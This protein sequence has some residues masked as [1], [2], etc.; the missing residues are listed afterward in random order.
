M[1][2]LMARW[3][4]ALGGMTLACAEGTAPNDGSFTVVTTTSGAG[5]DADGYMLRIDSDRR[6]RL[7]TSDTV[8]L[9]GLAAGGHELDLEGIAPNCTV[10]GANIRTVTVSPGD[11][12]FVRFDVACAGTAGTLQLTVM[13][14]GMDID[15]SGY[16]ALLDGL[17]KLAVGANA[18]ASTNVPSGT[19]QVTLAGVAA[20]CTL[21]DTGAR[22]AEIL[23][24]GITRVAFTLHCSASAPAGRG[25]E[26]AFVRDG[27]EG[28]DALQLNRMYLMNED[29]TSL[30]PL[31][32]VS[33][34]EHEAPDWLPDGVHL[35]F[36]GVS[37]D[38]GPSFGT[39]YILDLNNGTIQPVPQT[40][41]LGAARWSPDGSRIVFGE[42]SC[43][44]DCGDEPTRYYIVIANENGSARVPIASDSLD[45][46]D[47]AWFADGRGV[48]Y[49][50][51]GVGRLDLAR[52]NVEGTSE[53]AL[54][55]NFVQEFS[56]ISGARPSPDGSR[57]AFA[58]R[59][60]APASE[61]STQVYVMPTDGSPPVALTQGP[62][63]NFDPAW[64]RD[65]RRI[66]FV[67][68]RDGNYEIYVMDADG[69]NPLRLTN[70][71][72]RDTQPAWRP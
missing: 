22:V 35:G 23:T 13:T 20:N 59:P 41:S 70:D 54:G 67:S 49:V 38:A 43:Y 65:G 53:T 28:D 25:H 52:N 1:A 21:D 51:T 15:P 14:E 58:A 72:A 62:S 40:Y 2:A 10:S 61:T 37:F 68:D 9:G 55:D 6:E 8:V 3:W 30:R 5:T 66:A 7:G 12:A 63:N 69:A 31:P 36:E 19:Y 32:I 26:I 42:S 57:V 24:G 39:L 4:V 56:G 33:G 16:V 60:T 27:G 44:S 71:P 46:F 18:V 48:L 50:R 29:G 64:S 47:P 34:S 17:P 45:Y 11:S